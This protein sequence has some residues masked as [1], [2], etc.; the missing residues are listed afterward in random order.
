MLPL[1][2]PR[3]LSGARNQILTVAVLFSTEYTALISS[4]VLVACEAIIRILT[5]ALRASS[6]ALAPVLLSLP[7]LTVLSCSQFPP[8]PLLS[9]VAAPL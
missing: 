7:S 2:N 9:R 6:R 1:G 8:E 5:L 4:F 3:P